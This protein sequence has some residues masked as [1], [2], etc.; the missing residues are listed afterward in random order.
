[1]FAVYIF[2]TQTASGMTELQQFK[3]C[4]VPSQ[5]LWDPHVWDDQG[6]SQKILGQLTETSPPNKQCSEWTQVAWSMGIRSSLDLGV[7]GINLGAEHNPHERVSN[8]NVTFLS[9]L[10]KQPQRLF[11]VRSILSVTLFTASG[12]DDN[13][14]SSFWPVLLLLSNLSTSYAGPHCLNLGSTAPP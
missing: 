6:W 9:M 13:M 7:L 14:Q 8:E 5:P 10:L 2:S 12:H 4:F 1:M 3:L 11:S